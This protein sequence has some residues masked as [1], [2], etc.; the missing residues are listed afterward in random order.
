MVISFTIFYQLSATFSFPLCS[1]EVARLR[2]QHVQIQQALQRSQLQAQQALK[3]QSLQSLALKTAVLRVARSGGSH[4]PQESGRQSTRGSTPLRSRQ[5]MS[6]ASARTSAELSLEEEA[7]VLEEARRRAR[8]RIRNHTA[9]QQQSL[10]QSSQNK[11]QTTIMTSGNEANESSAKLPISSSS[12]SAKASVASTQAST[13]SDPRRQTT[14]SQPPR[15]KTPTVRSPA[16][17]AAITTLLQSA[18][19]LYWPSSEATTNKANAAAT[20]GVLSSSK[21][22]TSSEKASAGATQPSP[23]QVIRAKTPIT[24]TNRSIYSAAAL[25]AVGRGASP[26]TIARPSGVAT[27]TGPQQPKKSAMAQQLLRSSNNAPSA[28]SSSSSSSLSSSGTAGKEQV[29]NRQNSTTRAMAGDLIVSSVPP[30]TIAPAMRNHKP[31][32]ASSTASSSSGT[33][34]DKKISSSTASSSRV[35]AEDA[36]VVNYQDAEDAVDGAF[37]EML[38]GYST[39]HQLPTTERYDGTAV[40]YTEEEHMVLEVTVLRAWELP[41]C[42]GGTHPYVLVSLQQQRSGPSGMSV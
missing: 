36:D 40:D 17:S 13:P 9:M 23:Q 3:Q 25:S 31:F 19:E 29:S 2:L 8:L 6:S 30:S 34:R 35:L 18:D 41:E 10:T 14:P 21:H 22:V 16:V 42:L 27:A 38:L 11:P 4:R 24:S 33:S 15:A 7:I 20:S 26:N 28:P 5:A 39:H 1:R 37:E 32:A 12:S